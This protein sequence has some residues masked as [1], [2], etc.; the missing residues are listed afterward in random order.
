MLQKVYWL[1][2]GKEHLEHSSIYAAHKCALTARETPNYLGILDICV[3][4]PGP[5]LTPLQAQKLHLLVLCLEETGSELSQLDHIWNTWN[6]VPS[7][8]PTSAL[9]T[10]RGILNHARILGIGIQKP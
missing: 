2:V 4:S 5:F 10:A 9:S 1:R 3:C 7:A 8:H 6:V